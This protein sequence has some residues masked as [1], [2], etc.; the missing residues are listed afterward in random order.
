[1]QRERTNRRPPTPR[2]KTRPWGPRRLTPVWRAVIEVGFIVFLFYSNLL[3][4]EFTASNGHGKTLAFALIDI[5]TAANFGIA[6]ISALIG[7][8]VFE[9]LRRKL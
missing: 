9:Y 7:Y 5:F 2:T 4:G 1:M 8:V 6:L 3:M